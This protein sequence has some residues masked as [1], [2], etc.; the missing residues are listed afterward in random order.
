MS[1]KLYLRKYDNASNKS[2]VEICTDY[3]TNRSENFVAMDAKDDFVRGIPNGKYI[4]RG[5]TIEKL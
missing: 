4:I 1:K 2:V 5:F 3:T